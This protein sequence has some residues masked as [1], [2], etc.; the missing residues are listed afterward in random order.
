MTGRLKR[1]STARFFFAHPG[2][3]PTFLTALL[4]ALCSDP[5]R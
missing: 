5:T 3:F 2:I 1:A 4:G